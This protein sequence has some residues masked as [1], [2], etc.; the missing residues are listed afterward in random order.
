MVS[1]SLSLKRTLAQ[2]TFMKSFF[3]ALTLFGMVLADNDPG[4]PNEP[5]GA[6][7]YDWPHYDSTFGLFGDFWDDGN[8]LL[9]KSSTPGATCSS[10]FGHEA[11]WVISAC[12][13]LQEAVPKYE[14]VAFSTLIAITERLWS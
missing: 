3:V 1:S 14:V 9:V 5:G 12:R 2:I 8:K 6:K 11:V 7:S 13:D 4:S 10:E